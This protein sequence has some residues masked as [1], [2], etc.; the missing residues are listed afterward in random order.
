MQYA[1]VNKLKMSKHKLKRDIRLI[2]NGV[3]QEHYLY[4]RSPLTDA[5][6]GQ[7]FLT[8]TVQVYHFLIL[9]YLQQTNC[10]RFNQKP[11]K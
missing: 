7:W 3:D 1:S 10:S 11:I 4:K 8:S 9:V 5:S 6:A 2:E